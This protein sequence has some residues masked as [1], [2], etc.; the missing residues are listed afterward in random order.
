MLSVGFTQTGARGGREMEKIRTENL[1][2]I[3]L[4]SSSLV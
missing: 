3:L 1:I 4:P 2:I